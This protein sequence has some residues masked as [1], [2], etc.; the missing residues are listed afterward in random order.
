VAIARVILRD[1][2][3]LV[4][5]EATSAL[6]SRNEALIQAAFEPL[7]VGRT[8]L[9]IAHR[10]STIRNADLIV[11]LDRGRI[12]ERGRHENLLAG[13]GLYAGLYRQQS[14][15]DTGGA[16][17]PANGATSLGSGEHEQDGIRRRP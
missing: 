16:D 4:L 10:L 2:R 11:V 13:N 8:S 12:V 5:D 7:M 9:V 1:A 3:I 6:D 15:S 14:G 17:G